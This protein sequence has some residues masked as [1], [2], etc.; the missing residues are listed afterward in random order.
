MVQTNNEEIGNLAKPRWVSLQ[1]I[2]S[3]VA[4]L[5]KAISIPCEARL[6]YDALETYRI[7]PRLF[8]GSLTILNT[9]QHGAASSWQ[10]I[11]RTETMMKD[12][13]DFGFA[14]DWMRKD[15]GICFDEAEKL[16]IELPISKMIDKRYATLQKKGYGQAD[17]SA[18]IKQFD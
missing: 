9:L 5:V 14:I 13:F 6:G 11:N 12:E 10:M 3:V 15:L 1:G 17:T 18:L 4:L 16:G 8:R 7:S 2:I